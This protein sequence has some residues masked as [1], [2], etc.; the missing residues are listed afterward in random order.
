[1]NRIY[2]Y[3]QHIIPKQINSM[4]R[5]SIKCFLIL[6][7]ITFPIG[8]LSLKAQ[9]IADMEEDLMEFDEFMSLTL[10]PLDLL[11][12]R[13][14]TAPT[15]ELAVVAE[16]I[17]KSLLKKEKR[18][19][20]SFFSVRASWQY[21]K[22]GN[23]VTYSDVSTPIINSYNTA[24][25]TSY[26]VG[27]AIS[28]PFSDLFDLGGKVKRQKLQL[29]TAQLLKQQ[30]YESIKQQIVE[31]YATA[32]AQLNILKLRAESIVLANTQYT[33]VEKNFA[34]GTASSDELATQKENQSMT[35]QRFEDSK[36]E[37]NKSLL[38]LEIITNSVII[39]R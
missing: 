3:L 22:F 26:S 30:T 23:D 39:R 35:I 11:F 7:L 27:A 1:M 10:P 2:L 8:F 13:A 28:I 14:K 17:E 4:K 38:I 36:F 34:N 15:Y 25:Q 5:I 16:Q 9:E 12:E 29:K 19:W 20:L 31:L 32:K 33:I 21:G 24:A 6:F 37:L 18:A